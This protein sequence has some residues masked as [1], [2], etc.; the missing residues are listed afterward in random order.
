MWTT[1][2]ANSGNGLGSRPPTVDW[3]RRWGPES[4]PSWQNKRMD[5]NQLLVN[6]AI[7]Q[8]RNRWPGAQDSVAAAAVVL[9]DG[10]ILTSVSFDNFNA[11]ATLCAEAGAVAQAYSLGKARRGLGLRDQWNRRREPTRCWRPAGSARNAW[12]SGGPRSW[13]PCRDPG[14]NDDVGNAA[15]AGTEPVLLG[16]LVHRG[17]PLAL[18]RRTRGMSLP[19]RFNLPAARA[20]GARAL[21]RGRAR[22]RGADLGRASRRIVPARWPDSGSKSVSRTNATWSRRRAADGVP[23]GVGHL[24]VLAAAIAA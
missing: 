6:S 22:R 2:R 15:A 12:P 13:P 8:L 10:Q 3:S 11:A 21:T 19:R 18:D 14:G 9:E 7:E 16:N 17:R 23:A 20:P 1:T 24:D 4:C 5:P